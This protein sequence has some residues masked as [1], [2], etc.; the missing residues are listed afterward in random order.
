MQLTLIGPIAPPNSGPS[1]KNKIL[2]EE[3]QRNNIKVKSINTNNYKRKFFIILFKIIFDTNSI[4]I[5]ATSKNG[6][7][8]ICPFL[9]IRKIFRS[10]F[11]VEY[12]YILMPMGGNLH[13]EILKMKILKSVYLASLKKSSKIFVETK[14]L[15]EKLEILFSLNNVKYLPNFKKR[16][17]I[18]RPKRNLKDDSFKIIFLSSI[19]KSKGL[20]LLI[21]PIRELREELNRDIVLDIYG[22]I[23]EGYE[24]SFFNMV[25]K[26]I[27]VQYKGIVNSSEVAKIISQY[28][29]FVFPTYY[30][31]E[32]FPAVIIDAFIAEV[33]IL[34]SDNNYNEEIV[35][36]MIN[37]L[38]FKSKNKQDL[39]IKLKEIIENHRLREFFSKNNKI[40]KNKYFSDVVVKELI[41]VLEE[42]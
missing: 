20:E 10:L 27:F 6:R 1:I 8:L 35:R 17:E 13:N 5:L 3:L 21:D 29:L 26:N 36:H 23:R 4:I 7:N 16:Q 30:E 40:E 42:I 12:K 11:N 28:D 32:G 39:K 2:I 24:D 31:G 38:V 14:N 25:N 9:Y 37:G 41:K 33:P 19:K 15:K 22:P 34:C 18:E